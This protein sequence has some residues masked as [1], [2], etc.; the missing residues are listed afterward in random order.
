MLT[1][2]H[3]VCH[4]RFLA[5]VHKSSLWPSVAPRCVRGWVNPLGLGSLL[6]WVLLLVCV[7]PGICPQVSFGF[8][9]EWTCWAIENV[10][11]ISEHSTDALLFFKVPLPSHQGWISSLSQTLPGTVSFNLCL[12]QVLFLGIHFVGP[13]DKNPFMV[14]CHPS[15]LNTH[16][17]TFYRLQQWFSNF[18]H[19]S[20]MEILLTHWVLAYFQSFW[21]G[22]NLIAGFPP[23]IPLRFI[24]LVWK[25]E[26]RR[27]KIF[28]C[29]FTF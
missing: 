16:W 11:W 19:W 3:I 6:H 20:Y 25:A 18:T 10:D 7:L 5:S 12:V 15:C 26:L 17:A 14:L 23:P 29:W 9:Q 8:T 28:I 2:V 27:E 21:P 1:L 13:F 24:L 22:G 4:W